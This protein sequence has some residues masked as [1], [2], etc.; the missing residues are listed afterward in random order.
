MNINPFTFGNP[1]TEPAR[2]FGR[3]REQR[4]IVSRLLSSAHESTSVVGERRIG[5]TSLLMY[6][7]NPAV[8]ND[9]GLSPEKYCLIY[10]DFQGLTHIT[11]QRFWQR[12]LSKMERALILAEPGGSIRTFT[13]AGPRIA[14]LLKEVAARGIAVD[15]VKRLLTE[16]ESEG[17]SMPLAAKPSPVILSEPLSERELEVLRLLTTDLTSHEIARELYISVNT[18]RSHV[19]HIYDKLGVHSRAKAVQRA[20]ELDLL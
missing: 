12:V 3:E 17:K 16:L 6:L 7:A 13:G 2:F 18:V 10:I 11:P 14:G 1:I 20:Q 15:Y 4:Q 19:G 8:A 9:L 5:K